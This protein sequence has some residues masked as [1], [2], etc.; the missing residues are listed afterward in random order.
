MMPGHTTLATENLLLAAPEVAIAAGG[1]S[2]KPRLHIVAYTGGLMN[3][4]GWGDVAIRLDGL[5]ASGQVPLL[6]D[7]D[8]RVGGVVGHGEASV[9]EGRLIVAGVM[10]GAGEAARSDHQHSGSPLTSR[11]RN[12]VDTGSPVYPPATHGAG[13]G[14][15]SRR[16]RPCVA[17]HGRSTAGCSAG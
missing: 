11:G 15:W 9:V 8:A 5:D 3:V 7:H 1:E 2:R 6:A 13:G 14:A 10:S 16:R 12:A 17:A 4:P